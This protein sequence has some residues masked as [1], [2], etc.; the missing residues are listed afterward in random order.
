VF[1]LEYPVDAVPDPKRLEE[2]L[3]F[4]AGLL[5]TI[6]HESDRAGYVPGDLPP[7]VYDALASAE[8]TAGK[9]PGRLRGGQGFGLTKEQQGAVEKR[10]LAVAMDHY[11]SKGWPVRYVGDSQTWD[12]EVTRPGEKLIVEVK[13]TTSAGERVILTGA[14]VIK[15][16]ERYPMTALIVVH[17][18]ALDREAERPNAAGG[19]LSEICPWEIEQGHLQ[20]VSWV[21]HTGL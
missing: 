16:R 3:L 6:Y 1:A 15:Y 7:E 4:M 2:D 11:R 13:G 19:R 8:R 14:Q 10:A 12:L 18:I 9:R 5:G 21:Y 20:A 17:G